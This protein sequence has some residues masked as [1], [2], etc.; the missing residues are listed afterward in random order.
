ML[1]LVI[2][3]SVDKFAKLKDVFNFND[4]KVTSYHN[5]QWQP[6]RIQSMYYFHLERENDAQWHTILYYTHTHT[7]SRSLAKT[8][9]YAPRV[10]GYAQTRKRS[11]QYSTVKT[12]VREVTCTCTL[13]KCVVRAMSVLSGASSSASMAIYQFTWSQTKNETRA[14]KLKN[15]RH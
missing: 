5:G 6:I 13:A 12:T 15:W 14:K 7:H 10:A 2:L 4:T 3:L 9:L 1:N 8:I 11:R